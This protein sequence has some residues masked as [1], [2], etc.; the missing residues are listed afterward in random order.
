[1]SGTEDAGRVQ[2]ADRCRDVIGHRVFGSFVGCFQNP[3]TR[4]PAE[5]R[6]V[7]IGIGQ[8]V[9][10]SGEARALGL[11]IAAY[12]QCSRKFVLAKCTYSRRPV[13]TMNATVR[14]T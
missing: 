9:I 8:R 3:A 14:I 10:G 4:V 2:V 5:R 13:L 1:M 11:T 6:R 12:S 7:R